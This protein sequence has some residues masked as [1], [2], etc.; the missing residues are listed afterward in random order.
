I[1]E[2]KFSMFIR[3]PDN[4]KIICKLMYEIF[5]IPVF[6]LIDKRLIILE[7]SS[8]YSHNPLYLSKEALIG[9]LFDPSD[10]CEYPVFKET[11]Y[12]ENFFSVS[13][14][15]KEQFKGCILI[16]PSVYNHLSEE[17]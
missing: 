17:M 7:Y 1:V 10:S 9:K 12:M 14:V 15:E 8:N 3:N 2:V 13:L 5:E 6:L 11:N 16:G 4:L